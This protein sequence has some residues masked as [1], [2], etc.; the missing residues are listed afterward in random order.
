MN[1]IDSIINKINKKSR[2]PIESEFLFRKYISESLTGKNL[3]TFYNW[4]CPPRILDADKKG[5]LFI[6][7]CVNLEK[8]FRGETIDNFTEIPRVVKDKEREIDMLKFLK[9]LGLKFRFI[10]LIADTNAY[11]ITPYSLQ[12]LGKEKIKKVFSDFKRKIEEMIRKDYKFVEINTFLFTN[13]TNKYQ[14][15]YENAVFKALDILDS[16]ISKLIKP[17]TWNQQKE[18]IKGHLGFK[19]YQRKEI[20]DIAKRTIATYGAEGILFNLLSKTKNFSNCVWMNIEEADQR[21]IAITNCLRQ[22]SRLANLPMIF[23]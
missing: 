5:R 3:I 12:V 8:I 7:Y 13:L 22:K 23:L 10:K 2:I 18:Y 16:D 6:N 9:S 15:E 11:Y 21:T 4:E 1:K 19:E 20:I 14:K 17:K